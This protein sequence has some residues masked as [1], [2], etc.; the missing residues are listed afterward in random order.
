MSRVTPRYPSRAKA[1]RNLTPCD[2]AL[3][4]TG[5]WRAWDIP[6]PSPHVNPARFALPPDYRLV[7]E[8]PGNDDDEA[9]AEM[10]RVSTNRALGIW[11]ATRPGP[12]TDIR[13]DI[14]GWA[15]HISPEEG[16]GSAG[17]VPP[18]AILD[19]H[20][21]SLTS[22][23]GRVWN[24]VTYVTESTE[25]GT[26]YNLTAYSQIRAGLYLR[27]GGEGAGADAEGEALAILAS[28]SELAR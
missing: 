19:E 25:L 4:D 24:V 14:R 23:G 6:W 7:G 17:F 3:P 26:L 12:R 9:D 2:R 22:V 28:F 8:H 15:F 5:G 21:C 18:P 16:Y 1:S 27:G 13:P 20:E 11:F 10:F